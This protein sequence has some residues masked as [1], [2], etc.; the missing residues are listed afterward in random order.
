MPE[1]R[2][3]RVFGARP[4]SSAKRRRRAT[5]AE[6]VQPA[7]L[8]EIRWTDTPEGA[9]SVP[10]SQRLVVPRRW[11]YRRLRVILGVVF[12]CRCG[13]KGNPPRSPRLARLG[14]ALSSTSTT[15]A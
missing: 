5:L 1:R 8:S 6:E 15:Y 14:L 4:A 9:K 11:S 2:P 3:D 10:R 12:P 7:K 13:G